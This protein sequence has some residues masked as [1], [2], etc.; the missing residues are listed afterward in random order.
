M[1]RRPLTSRLAVRMSSY[2]TVS[3]SFARV[4][5][6]QA[7]P[8]LTAVEI[9]RDTRLPIITSLHRTLVALG[10]VISSY[11]ARSGPFELIERVVFEPRDGGKL[12]A[13]LGEAA[14]AAILELVGDEGSSERG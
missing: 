6:E 12:E 14:K 13:P 5:F 2:V 4:Q 8:H 7:G 3:R 9:V 10:L 1:S 11:Q